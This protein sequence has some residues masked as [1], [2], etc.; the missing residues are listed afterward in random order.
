[1]T[2]ALKVKFARRFLEGE[3]LSWAYLNVHAETTVVEFESN[4]FKCFWSEAKQARIITEF[5][6]VPRYRERNESMKEFCE[7][8]L[9]K[10]VHI[11][12]PLD[13]L[14]K[15]DA[16]K[17]R[18]PNKW[19]W[20]LVYSPD[21]TID[22]LLNYVEKLDMAEDRNERGGDRPR[23]QNAQ[24]SR[25]QGNNNGNRDHSDGR[26]GGRD[27]SNQFHNGSQGENTGENR[28]HN[29][30]YYRNNNNYYYSGRGGHSYQQ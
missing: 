8:R 30:G 2:G 14:I 28:Q 29:T 23:D 1:M 4:F 27:N 18:L 16:L 12:K 10:L 6:N 19:Y 11:D 17:K 9:K 13:D 26:N 5:L 22:N 15:I 7:D 21:D 3:A 25:R 24:E 20:S